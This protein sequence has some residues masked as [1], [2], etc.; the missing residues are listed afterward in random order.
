MWRKDGRIGDR[1]DGMEDIVDNDT[2]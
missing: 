1:R 2:N